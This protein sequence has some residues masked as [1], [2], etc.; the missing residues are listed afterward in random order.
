MRTSRRAPGVRSW[1]AMALVGSLLVP[2][3]V[4]V[5]QGL[6]A[7]L[8][9]VKGEV[10]WSPAG[11]TQYQRVGVATVVHTGDRL[12][13]AENSAARLAYFE[14]STTDLGA[15]TGVRL[16]N[17]DQSPAGTVIKLTQVSGTTQAHVQPAAANTSYQVESPA[18]LAS[19]P[20]TTCPWVRVSRDGTTLV[21]NYLNM[22]PLAI[23]PLAVQEIIYSTGWQP[24]PA[25]PRL[26]Q[27]AILTTAMRVI[28][29]PAG[30]DDPAL[31]VCAFGPMTAG[32]A[33]DGLA[34]DATV[35]GSESAASLAGT[36]A[37]AGATHEIGAVVP[38]GAA[39]RVLEQGGGQVIA[40][41][42][43]SGGQFGSV[44]L[45]PGQ[46]TQ[47]VVGQPPSTPA[48]IGTHTAMAVAEAA[49]TR[50][51]SQATG[52]NLANQTFLQNAVGFGQ[53]STVQAIIDSLTR[54]P[55]H[56]RR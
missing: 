13:T 37:I 6:E 19:A 51:R 7:T 12:R 1:L 36:I 11:A 28:A 46:E 32:L 22:P 44:T 39:G 52:S 40:V 23:E 30:F 45:L 53:M 29:I 4:L 50:A 24:T 55:N 18:A 15:T 9:D 42:N 21:R 14:G 35:T 27:Q 25:G 2:A 26:G 3:T 5:A 54:P 49:S 56:N 38:A 8:I 17:L 16:D 31:A 33:P 20:P 47:V 48:S 10:E 34:L 41:R 43:T